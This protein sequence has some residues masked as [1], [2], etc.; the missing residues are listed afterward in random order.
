MKS[1]IA[2]RANIIIE[3]RK[4]NK[5]IEKEELHNLIVNDGRERVAKLINGISAASFGYI[6]I[7]TG[8][9]TPVVGDSALQ[10]EVKRANATETYESD[11]KAVFE[12]TFT[13]GSGESY[14]ITEAGVFDQL[15]P[16]GST[17]L[18][19]FVFSIKAV[20]S[21]TELYVKV[22]ITVS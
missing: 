14:N 15:T 6:A 13:F 11:Y 16:S 21:D 4:G 1:R 10:T 5:I 12:K 22:T 7:G 3:L 2:L 20:D 8:T 19:R 18:D 9:N 17:M